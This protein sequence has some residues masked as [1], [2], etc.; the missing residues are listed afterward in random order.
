MRRRP[1]LSAA[2]DG[3]GWGRSSSPPGAPETAGEDGIAN[4]GVP[5]ETWGRLALPSVRGPSRRSR[6]RARVRLLR[7]GPLPR[8]APHRDWHCHGG[9]PDSGD[10]RVGEA[11]GP[12]GP[13]A[14]GP[15]V[16]AARGLREVGTTCPCGSARRDARESTCGVRPPEP[17]RHASACGAAGTPLKPA[18]RPGRAHVPW[19]G[20]GARV[21]AGL[22]SGRARVRDRVDVRACACAPVCPR[23]PHV[24]SARRRPAPGK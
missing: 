11:T 2:G 16:Y 20:A 17:V 24:G 14:R 7:R 23:T 1:T 18:R 21:G 5:C 3:R 15:C 19:V 13:R 22:A 12:P 4:G 10:R 6:S 9:L 8:R